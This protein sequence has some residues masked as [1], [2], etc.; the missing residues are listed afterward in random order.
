MSVLQ[1]EQALLYDDLV[2]CF[3]IRLCQHPQYNTETSLH[4]SAAYRLRHVYIN[5]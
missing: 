5:Q 4:G 3:E 2:G 1:P